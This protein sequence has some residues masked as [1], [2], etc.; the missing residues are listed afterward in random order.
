MNSDETSH[1]V[2]TCQGTNKNVIKRGHCARFNGT[3]LT[4]TSHSP[5]LWGWKLH[6]KWC[7]T[8]L[9][10]NESWIMNNQQELIEIT[11]RTNNE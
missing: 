11:R 5:Q 3:L 10:V 4:N 7:I 2:E 8:G 6:N 9:A 1:T